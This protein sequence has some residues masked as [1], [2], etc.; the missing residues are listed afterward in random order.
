MT[1]QMYDGQQLYIS[2]VHRNSTNSR[3]SIIHRRHKQFKLT[4]GSKY[5]LFRLGII[6]WHDWLTVMCLDCLCRLY[7]I[8]IG[9]QKLYWSCRQYSIDHFLS[10]VWYWL[11]WVYTVC[12]FCL[13]VQM[14]DGQQL[15][16]SHVHRNIT[17]SRRSIIHRRH[18]R[19]QNL[20]KLLQVMIL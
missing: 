4:T 12:V 3:R 7:T 17:N 10:P 20:Q 18:H 11:S 14:Y 9:N 15:Y 19:N 6:D 8:S 5:W 13:T 16:I 2:H 1:V